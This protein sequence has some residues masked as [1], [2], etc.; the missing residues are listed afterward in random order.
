MADNILK[1]DTQQLK[2][3]ADTVRKQIRSMQQAFDSLQ[4]T[5]SRSSY[6]WQGQAADEYRK[7]FS[8]ERDTTAE[9]FQRLSD[10]PDAL[11]KIAGV[12]E[13]GEDKAKE[14]ASGL[15]TDFI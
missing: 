9:M 11:E 5:V 2:T 15:P 1:V 13:G 14:I 10:I 7:A 12:Y 4:T 8:G 6:Y 3:T